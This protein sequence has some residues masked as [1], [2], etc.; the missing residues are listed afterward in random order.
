MSPD[1]RLKF[2]TD[3]AVAEEDFERP[4]NVALWSDPGGVPFLSKFLM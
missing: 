2:Q 1:L 4:S 3:L